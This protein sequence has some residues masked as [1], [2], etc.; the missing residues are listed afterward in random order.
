LLELTGLNLHFVHEGL[1]FCFELIVDT[2]SWN[3]D[4]IDSQKTV[5]GFE[6]SH[7]LILQ[8][9][10]EH[11]ILEIQRLV[12]EVLNESPKFPKLGDGGVI[13]DGVQEFRFEI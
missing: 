12:G 5:N 11:F 7:Q 4:K 3:I 10:V 1:H 8:S 13:R 2:F 6:L 9:E